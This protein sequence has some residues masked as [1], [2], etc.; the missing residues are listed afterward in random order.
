MTKQN[1]ESTYEMKKYKKVFFKN[2]YLDYIC[3]VYLDTI[4][5]HF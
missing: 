3:P 5:W 1:D 2:A 4:K